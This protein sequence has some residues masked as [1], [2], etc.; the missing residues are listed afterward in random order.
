MARKNQ[1]H[2]LLA[3]SYII[4]VIH[5]DIYTSDV[6]GS[7][8]YCDLASIALKLLSLLWLNADIESLFTVQL[9]K[10]C[11]DKSEKSYGSKI[12]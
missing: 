4:V 2:T 7:N 6:S 10:Y 12:T 1:H 9:D 11:E 5:V 3:R 8:P